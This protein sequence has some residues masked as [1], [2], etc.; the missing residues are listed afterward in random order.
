MEAPT[1]EFATGIP[2]PRLRPFVTGYTGYRLTGLTPG[3]HAGLP[4][5][6]LTFIVA[7]DDPLDVATTPDD[8][9]RDAYWGMLAGLHARPARVRHR[10][11]QHGVQLAITPAGATALFGVPAAEL[12]SMAVHLDDVAPAFAA[13]LVDRLSAARSWR[14]R[15]AILDAVFLAVVHD[16]VATTPQL[17]QAWSRL[18]A[19]HGL[20]GIAELAAEVGW[21]RRHLAQR[22]RETFGL[23]PKVLA[24]VV[25][26]ERAQQLLRLP[27]RPSLAGV[28]AAC[29]YADQAHM[30]REWNELAGRPPSSWLDDETIQFVQD[31][32]PPAPSS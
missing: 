24:R 6:S 2:H 16:E 32:E 29:G 10:G 22:F 27:T 23:S 5:R 7:F 31:D 9:D 1:H 20:I 25:R 17:E 4:S 19:S 8:A 15:W 28:A 3:E 26:F 14:A 11:R 13:Q 30:T 21:S 12:A 18:V